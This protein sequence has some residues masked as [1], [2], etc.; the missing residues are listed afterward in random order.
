MTKKIYK[1]AVR[2]CAGAALLFCASVGA[3]EETAS[4]DVVWS[5]EGEL[6][7][8][9]TTGNT[10]TES[11]LLKFGVKRE[12]KKWLASVRVEDL[13]KSEDG[14]TTA[15]RFFA[16]VKSDY[17]LAVRHYLFGTGDYEDDRF[18][19]YDYRAN[20]A[21]GYGYRVVDLPSLAINGEIGPGGRWSRETDTGDKTAEATARLAG[22]LT[23]RISPTAKLTEEVSAVRGPSNTVY[24][25][26][27]ALTTNINSDL[28]LRVSY[29]YKHTTD[30]PI[31]TEKTDTETAVT[32]VYSF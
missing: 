18:S 8:T 1:P 31:D 14:V 13:D 32:L 5:G 16:V 27:T 21:V 3:V 10:D 9:R 20:A 23:W 25:S 30:V 7:Y 11:L 26:L 4:P 2:L 15:D 29:L 19:G 24:R 22:D 12:S 6:G 17:K 28:A